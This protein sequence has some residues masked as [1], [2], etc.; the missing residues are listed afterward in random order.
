MMWL[1]LEAGIAGLLLVMIVWWT[2]PSKKKEE[3]PYEAHDQ[4]PPAPGKD[5]DE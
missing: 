5:G 3:R 2:L 1:L 4:S